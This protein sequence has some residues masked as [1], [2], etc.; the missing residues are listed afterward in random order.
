MREIQDRIKKRALALLGYPYSIILRLSLAEEAATLPTHQV[1]RKIQKQMAKR[2]W[3]TADI[4]DTL[5]NPARTVCTRDMR[6]LPNGTSMN[7]P[8]TAYLRQDGHYVVRNDRTGD[9][10][11]ISNRNDPTW[12]TPF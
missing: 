3:T 8:A 7:D 11:Q 6:Y 4:E 9:I 2:G 1:G 5:R 10:V 12:E